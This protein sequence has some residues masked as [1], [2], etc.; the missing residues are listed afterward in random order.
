[1]STSFNIVNI[2]RRRR[3]PAWNGTT[4]DAGGLSRKKREREQRTIAM[5]HMLRA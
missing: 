4:L 5:A 3:R 1:L 2:R